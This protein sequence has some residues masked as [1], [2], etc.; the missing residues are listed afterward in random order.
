MCAGVLV[1]SVALGDEE[2]LRRLAEGDERALRDLFAAYGPYARALALRVVGSPTLA[3]EVVQE[4]FLSIWQHARNY[5][6]ER[7][8]VRA[9]LFA[10]V[11]NRAVD[12]VRREE[13]Y[14]RRAQDEETVVVLDAE[15]VAES[16]AELQE[17]A[18]RR[19]EIREALQRLPAEQRAVLELMYFEGKTQ[20]AIAAETGIPLGTVK[21][22]T[23]LGMRR[24]RKDLEIEP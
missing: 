24:L 12:C 1:R 18:N 5:R 22:R 16:V 17:L 2:L 14:R 21:S 23:L 20:A 7:G 4:A 15:D 3:D 19:R 11:H 13:A 9:W 8:S 10:T 6:R